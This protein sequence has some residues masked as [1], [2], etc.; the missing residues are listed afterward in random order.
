MT[1]AFALGATLA[2]ALLMWA[3]VDLPLPTLLVWNASASAPIGLY[4][5][6]PF[7][8]PRAGD[9]VIVDPPAPVADFLAARQYLPR[10]VPLIK[11]VAA[12]APARVCRDGLVISVSLTHAAV[13]ETLPG[14]VPDALSDSAVT[15]EA[16]ATDRRGRGLPTWSGCHSLTT[17][18]LFLLNADV[19]QSLDGR[20]F[21]PTP[22]AS[23]R[24]VV[25]PLFLPRVRP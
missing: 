14:A 15:V 6:D 3:P 1:R 18:E 23:I 8:S 4:R 2:G 21:G 7:A 25:H 11:T 19:A 20:Y 10:G 12:M 22:K 13:P 9:R 17:D 24:G 5:V 16:Q